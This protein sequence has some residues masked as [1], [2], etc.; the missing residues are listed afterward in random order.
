MKSKFNKNFII[1]I[2]IVVIIVFVLIKIIGIITEPKVISDFKKVMKEY[3][4]SV[5]NISSS[6]IQAQEAKTGRI[7]KAKKYDDECILAQFKDGKNAEA[8]F[9][10]MCLATNSSG[11]KAKILKESNNF[12]N[13]VN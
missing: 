13:L 4:Y 6:A 5:K 12:F 8:Y 1:G 11:S 3:G 2:I 10:A 9:E 7:V